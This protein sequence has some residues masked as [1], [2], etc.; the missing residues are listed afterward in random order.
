M[1]EN[2][3]YFDITFIY[4]PS[5]ISQVERIAAQLRATGVS[6][7]FNEGEFGRTAESL[8]QVKSSILRAYTV[9]FVMS[10]DS[11]ES[12][13]CNELLEYA[14]GKNK[15]LATLILNDDI[16][17]DVHP[18]IAQNPYVFF[19]DATTIWPP[20]SMSCAPT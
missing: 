6:A 14:V 20:E 7:D 13:L 9:G 12:Q 10:P 17:V 2:D 16:G 19:R 15:R 8:K 18:A 3:S 5:D 4:H 1:R 11:A